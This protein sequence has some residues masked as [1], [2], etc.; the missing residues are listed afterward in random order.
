VPLQRSGA[1][2]FAYKLSE[3]RQL[4]SEKVSKQEGHLTLP[5][6]NT[7]FVSLNP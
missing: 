3:R 7:Y 4:P 2:F 6:A 1:P 5:S